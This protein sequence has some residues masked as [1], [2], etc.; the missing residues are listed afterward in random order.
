MKNLI[1]IAAAVLMSG[2]SSGYK[3][4]YQTIPGATPEAIAAIRAG[5]PPATPE[6]RR[7]APG[8]PAQMALALRQK[9][10]EIIGY[11][12]FNSGSSESE[13]GAIEQGKK[14]GADLVVIVNP[15]Y[16]GT[17]TSSVPITTPTMQTSYTT[18]SATAYGAGGTVNAY[19]SSTTT[20]HGS[21]TNYIPISVNR[22]DYSAA[23]LVR[24]RYNLGLYTRDLSNEERQAIQSNH[25][26]VIIAVVEGTPAFDADFLTGDIITSIGE[27]KISGAA[28]FQATAGANAGKL[29]EIS[30]IRNGML[31]TKK[32]QMLRR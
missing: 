15:I 1:I 3:A 26:A 16:T 14:V 11:S 8:D 18:G 31:M 4:F 29:V 21:Q 10:Y 7:V 17:V 20:T 13:K 28:S 23:F 32:V 9:G 19:G 5:S 6:L 22:H 25:G 24:Q 27:S 30:F 2:C 12:S